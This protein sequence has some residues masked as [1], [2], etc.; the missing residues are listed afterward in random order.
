[1]HLVY[2]ESPLDQLEPLGNQLFINDQPA[3][4]M[5]R[6]FNGRLG[7]SPSIMPKH[8]RSR[9]AVFV[10][11]TWATAAGPDANLQPATWLSA[12]SPFRVIH[13]TTPESVIPGTVDDLR[14]FALLKT[15]FE[16]DPGIVIWGIGATDLQRNVDQDE[17]GRRLIFL[18]QATLARGALP[19]LMTIPPLPDVEQENSRLAAL[20]AKRIGHSLQTP[21]I[22]LYSRSL[23]KGRG[24]GDFARFFYSAAEELPLR[25]LN[26]D[27]RR[28]MCEIIREYLLACK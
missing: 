4:L 15:V 21:V 26:N 17:I 1:L 27:G 23:A 7:E 2:P 25:T 12:H 6:P 10:D 22:D 28:W 5:T 19:M 3:V 11:E 16:Q 18:A 20:E 14:K 13:V 24:I 8:K 9:V